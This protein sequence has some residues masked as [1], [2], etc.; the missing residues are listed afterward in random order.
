MINLSSA[1]SNKKTLFYLLISVGI[2][3]FLATSGFIIVAG[4]VAFL[5]VVGLFIPEADSS[6]MIHDTLFTQISDV[7]VKA[8][9]GNLSERI[10]KIPT[11]HLLESVAWG[12]NDMLDQTEQMMRDIRASIKAA[13]EGTKLRRIF[14][15]GYKGDYLSASPE[16]NEAI[17]AIAVGFLGKMRSELSFEFERSSGGISKGIAVIQDNLR[18]NSELSQSIND[19][20]SQT[21][22]NVIKSQETVGEIIGSLEHLIENINNS[23]TSITSLNNR[24]N[25]IATIANMIKDIAEQTNLL[26]LNAAIEAARAGEHG[27]GFA[28]VADEVRKLAERTQKATAEISMTLQTLK[29]EAGDVLS[30][31]ENMTNIASQA[32]S[33]INSFRGILE[34]F[35]KTASSAAYMSNHINGSLFT[36]LVKVDHIIFKHNA[37]SAIINLNVE[38]AATFTDH[39]NCRMGK[40]YYEGDGKKLFSHTPS[41]KKMEA[42]HADVHTAVLET[43]KCVGRGDC[44]ISKNKTLIVHNMEKMENSS[45]ILF[46]LLD[47][48]LQEAN[49]KMKR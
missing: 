13:N 34:D 22:E 1:F 37:Y 12:I 30:N 28:V 4:V 43:I 39:H 8:G 44:L 27:R 2:A 15:Q 47:D 16:L 36:A 7:V 19:I 24:T 17:D 20:T 38:K 3:I 29:Q 9:A 23:N 32:Q 33:D 6:T 11:H 18:Q 41:Y 45:K 25:D 46:T 35:S 14:H 42:P 26:S 21:A 49:P 31:A 40:W 10:T 48:M 5:I